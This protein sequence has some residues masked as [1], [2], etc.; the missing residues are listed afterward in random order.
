MR[1]GS[2]FLALTLLSACKSNEPSIELSA[3]PLPSSELEVAELPNPQTP[4]SAPPSCDEIPPCNPGEN[5]SPHQC[6]A[7]RY[8]GELLWDGQRFF[9]WGPN[10]CHAKR[11]LAVAACKAGK[12]YTQLGDLSC[13]PDSSKGACPVA[14]PDCAPNDQ[15]K[16][17]Y[18]KNYLGKE[19]T[20]D[21]RPTAW[22]A[23][24]CQTKHLVLVRA[25][26]QG[27]D[28]TALSSIR[29]EADPQPG[30]CPPAPPSC[31][32]Q[33]D[34]ER[35][36]TECLLSSLGDS[37][38]KKPWKAL[39]TSSCEAQYRLRELLC[40]YSD[41]AKTLTLESLAGMECRSLLGQA[42]RPKEP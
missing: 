21:Q 38:L 37:P 22:G 26:E 32:D 3:A 8:G 11:A 27:L 10:L 2:V 20:W 17:C 12:D 33:V 28:P 14:A 39:G 23:G 7:Y 29:C 30:L 40:R 34:Q 24:E 31:S 25:C 16:R 42:T 5:N 15:A 13:A 6:V 4:V 18:A 9:A 36:P 41:T 1:C 35:D 19:L